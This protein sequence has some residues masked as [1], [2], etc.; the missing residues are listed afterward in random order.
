VAT[1]EA[2]ELDCFDHIVLGEGEVSF[3]DLLSELEKGG[4]PA[5]VIRGAPPDIETLPYP[6][7][8]LFDYAAG[9]AAHPW[10]PS[11]EK[12]F[13]SIMAGRG[14][15]FR[16]AFC[17]PA[18]RLIFG[19]RSKIRSNASIIAEL[20]L[21]R[22]R[23]GY[24]SLL[25]HDDLFTL[26]KQQVLEFCGMYRREG[27]P[28]SFTCQARADF[29]VKNEDAVEELV[30][31][32]LKC[33]MI[34]FESGSQRVLD[35][36]KKGTTVEQNL[37]AAEVCAR[38]GIMVF[39]NYMFGVPGETRAEVRSTVDF[40]RR[41]KPAYPSPAFFTPYPGTELGDRCRAEGL[42]LEATGSY[43]NRAAGTGGKIKGVDYDFL[44][45]AAA[46]SLEYERPAGA[47][48]PASG[49]RTLLRKLRSAAGRALRLPGRLRQR[50]KYLR[51]GL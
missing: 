23:Y 41:I 25:I 21:L 22:A 51:Y 27:L 38:H 28:P 46:R 6:D 29:I 42:L 14:C 12:P 39:A 32:G 49:G 30:K 33:F 26:N 43:Y 4:A 45:A 37:A 1:G 11:M 40:I 16:C 48:P 24:R 17:Q 47:L 20:K 31:S 2:E 5:R 10:L 8:E 7:R 19:G 50:L 35:Y 15:P 3:S 9:E 34:G 13:A 18:E 44:A 36:L